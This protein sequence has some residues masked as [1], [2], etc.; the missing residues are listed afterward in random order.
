MLSIYGANSL[1]R[2]H[3]TVQVN[4]GTLHSVVIAQIIPQ[5]EYCAVQCSAQYQT[6]AASTMNTNYTGESIQVIQEDPIHNIENQ[7][8]IETN[9]LI[10]VL[11][12]TLEVF[13]Q[14]QP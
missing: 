4:Q 11:T 13:E 5:M 6:M 14:N 8:I 10:K 12:K 1:H 2:F 3:V 9:S 7:H